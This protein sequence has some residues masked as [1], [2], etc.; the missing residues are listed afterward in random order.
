[1]HR[2][3][4]YDIEL[5]FYFLCL[6]GNLCTEYTMYNHTQFD[7]WSSDKE[8]D[9]LLGQNTILPQTPSIDIHVHVIL[10][11]TIP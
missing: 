5:V 3:A 6:D 4:H 9:C 11:Q 10:W 7:Q 2:I 8:D 1:M